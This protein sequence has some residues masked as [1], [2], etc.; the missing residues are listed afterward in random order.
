VNANLI[1]TRKRLDTV[2]SSFCLAKWLQVTLHLQNGHNHSCH[3]PGTHQTPLDEL[4]RDPSALHNTGFKKRLRR[5]MLTGVRPAECEYCWKVEDASP[6][7]ISDRVVKSHDPWAMPHFD[8]I[9][10]TPWDAA[11]TPSYVEVSFS[12]VC[13]FA[14][15]YCGPW[16]SS[17]WVE[18]IRQHGP[19]VGARRFNNLEDLVAARRMPIPE[20]EENPYV[21]AFWE[22]WPTLYPKLEVF[23]ITG[24]EPLLSKHTMRVLRWIRDNPRADLHLAVNSNLGVPDQLY[25]EFLDLVLEIV[26]HGCVKRFELYTSVDAYAARAEYIRNGLNYRQWLGNV[27]RYL[28]RVPDQCLVI[29]STFNALSITSFLRLYA[30]VLDLRAGYPPQDAEGEPGGRLRIDLPYLRNPDHQSV[31]ILPS[32]YVERMDDIVTSVESAPGSLKMESVQLRRIRSL[33]VQQMPAAKLSQARASFYNFFAEHDRRRGTSF[34]A[35]FPEMAS[36]WRL[37]R[38]QAAAAQPRRSAS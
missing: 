26:T 11:A 3:H 25:E 31:M 23:R 9:R 8:K 27:R 20:R 33:M 36:F 1:D 17:K 35:T 18:E 37:C 32:D 38:E 12:N 5:D 10:Q 30:D 14:C 15:S 2:S 7:N 4:A 16:A 22:W 28:E 34:L 13:N 6:D 21:D 24:G 19:Y 29:M